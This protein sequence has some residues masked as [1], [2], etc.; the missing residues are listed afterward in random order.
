M[1]ICNSS[2]KI[3]CAHAHF[4]CTVAASAFP[5]EFENDVATNKHVSGIVLKNKCGVLLSNFQHGE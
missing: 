3:T 2:S 5:T 1:L 4:V